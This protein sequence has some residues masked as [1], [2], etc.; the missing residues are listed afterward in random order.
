MMRNAEELQGI[1]GM[2]Y[3]ASAP[4]GEEILGIEALN[5]KIYLV[6]KRALYL[7]VADK[8]LGLIAEFSGPDGHPLDE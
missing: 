8:R 6:T 2:E 4:A 3:L 7:L 1:E 5:G